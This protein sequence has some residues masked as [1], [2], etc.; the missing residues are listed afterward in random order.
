MKKYL[1]FT[2]IELLLTVVIVAILSG[3]VVA[4][5]NPEGLRAKARDTNRKKD[6][7]LVSQ[8]LGQYYADNNAYPSGEISA[9]KSAISPSSGSPIYLKTFPDESGL[10]YTYVDSQNYIL[11]AYLEAQ[12]NEVPSGVTA[13]APSA[14]TATTPNRYCVTNPF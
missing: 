11:C 7:V 3:L 8:A 6:V 5:I 2:L 14:A 13:C 12:P 1:A 10:C 9:V 4:A